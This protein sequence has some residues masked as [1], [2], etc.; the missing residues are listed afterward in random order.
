MRRD[1]PLG[2]MR[3]ESGVP[4]KGDD[5]ASTRRK[6]AR[7]CHHFAHADSIDR[8]AVSPDDDLRAPTGRVRDCGDE[9]V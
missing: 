8:A 6:A 7:D 2:V 5:F 4:T 1:F 3:A 9:R